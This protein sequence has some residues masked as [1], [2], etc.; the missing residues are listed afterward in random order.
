MSADPSILQA[1]LIGYQYQRDQIDAKMAEIRRELGGKAAGVKRSGLP[2]TGT[3]GT[4][5][6]R[7]VSPAGRR[8]M[9]AAQRKRWAAVKAAKPAEPAK[10]PA[11]KKRKMSAAGRKRIA[12]ATRKRWAEFRAKKGAAH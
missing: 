8:R 5:A 1:A 9:A 12:D 3:P 6:K 2:A 7:V 11:P 10:Q 4:S